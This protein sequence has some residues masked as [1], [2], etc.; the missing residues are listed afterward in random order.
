MRLF[1]QD[2]IGDWPSVFRSVA[3]ELDVFCRGKGFDGSN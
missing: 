1:R 3:L 2:E